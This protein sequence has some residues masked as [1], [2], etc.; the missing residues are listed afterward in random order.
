MATES[1][2]FLRF[3]CRSN[4]SSFSGRKEGSEHVVWAH[5]LLSSASL[6]N[7]YRHSESRGLPSL[8]L[9]FL[10]HENDCP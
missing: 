2:M 3:S 10:I 8:L 7:G 1:T 4:C 6:A 9:H 5:P